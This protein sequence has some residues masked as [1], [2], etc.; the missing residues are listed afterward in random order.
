MSR[1]AFEAW[2]TSKP[3]TNYALSG[4]P[5]DWFYEV[6]QA[7]EAEVEA[8]LMRAEKAE[9]ERDRLRAAIESAIRTMESV[10]VFV[11][12][13]EHIKHPEGNNWYDD[14]INTLRHTFAEGKL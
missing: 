11:T 4:N 8:T 2:R 6:W 13:R 14:A 7:S 5:V 9:A 10:K 12:S 3:L 1:E